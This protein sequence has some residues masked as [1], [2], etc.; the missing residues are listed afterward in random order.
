[1]TTRPYRTI[2]LRCRPLFQSY[3]RRLLFLFFFRSLQRQLKAVRRTAGALVIAAWL[4]A[5]DLDHDAAMRAVIVLTPLVLLAMI[6]GVV[7]GI[8]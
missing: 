6:S 5:I 2:P 3:S 7:S 8:S 4:T 1:M